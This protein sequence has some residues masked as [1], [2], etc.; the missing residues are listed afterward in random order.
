MGVMQRQ[1]RLM[2]LEICV[3][4][5]RRRCM[6]QFCYAA[7]M[8]SVKT[9]FLNGLKERGLAPCAEHWLDLLIFDHMVTDQ[10]VF[11]ANCSNLSGNFKFIPVFFPTFTAKS[12]H[13]SNTN[14]GSYTRE[15]FHCCMPKSSV[16]IKHA[17]VMYLITSILPRWMIGSLYSTYVLFSTSDTC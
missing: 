2:Q 12:G 10:P 9:V 8:S 5:A 11:S 16:C 13:F 6:P 1:S 7:S 3:L 4:Y 14:L 17:C 15:I